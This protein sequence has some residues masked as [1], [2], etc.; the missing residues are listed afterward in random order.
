M[1]KVVSSELSKLMANTYALYLKTQNYHWHV[2]GANFIALHEFLEGHYKELADA[3]D[4]LA[5]RIVMLG[6]HAPASFS[7]IEELSE[8]VPGD[9]ATSA[10]NM[11]SQLAQDHGAM[12]EMIKDLNILAENDNDLSTCNLLMERI[13]AHEKM[14]WMLASFAK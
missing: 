1:T 11:L 12:I 5:E 3:I 6:A 13:D 7:V 8:I 4:S 2:R 10:E 9:P 14:R